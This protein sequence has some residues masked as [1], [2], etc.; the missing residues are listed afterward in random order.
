M[1]RIISPKKRSEQLKL[2]NMAEYSD[3]YSFMS[4]LER[5]VCREWGDPWTKFE[6]A[7]FYDMLNEYLIAKDKRWP[8]QGDNL[9]DALD[10]LPDHFKKGEKEFSLMLTKDKKG[11]WQITY[12]NLDELQFESYSDD[13][14]YRSLLECVLSGVSWLRKYV[15]DLR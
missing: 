9:E 8:S 1:A 5:E 4:H 15:K 3:H 2:L 6:R 12:A 10:L 11:R 13:K 7:E 14:N